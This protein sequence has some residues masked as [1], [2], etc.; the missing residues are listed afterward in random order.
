[1]S[2]GDLKNLMDE[3]IQAVKDWVNELTVNATLQLVKDLTYTFT[4]VDTSTLLSNWTI[5]LGTDNNQFIAAHVLGEKGST[6]EDSASIAYDLTVYDLKNREYGETI[7]LSNNTPYINYVND[8]TERIEPRKFV[9]AAL[10]L[11]E[12][13]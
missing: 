1:M 2:I 4:P 10:A 7:Y 13:K 6:R 8:G 5:S 9:E 11:F 12:V 3:E